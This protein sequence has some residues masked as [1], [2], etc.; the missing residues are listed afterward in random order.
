MGHESCTGKKKMCMG[1]WL[2]NQK[3]GIIVSSGHRW[4]D[5]ITVDLTEAGQSLCA[6]LI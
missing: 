5:N 4:K 1:L 3:N 2:G 6:G